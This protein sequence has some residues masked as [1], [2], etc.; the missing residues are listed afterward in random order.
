MSG[1]P[2]AMKRNRL[3]RSGVNALR[4]RTVTP[5]DALLVSYPKSGN[6]WLKFMLAHA[7]TGVAATF[8]A[9]EDAIGTVGGRTDVPA[10]LPGGGRI[11]KSLEAFSTGVRAPGPVVYVVRDGRDVAVSYYQQLVRKGLNPGAFSSYL[12][13]FVAGEVDG[14]GPWGAHV[15]SWLDRRVTRERRLL[16]IRYE[17]LLEDPLGGLQ[18][19]LEFLGATVDAEVVEAAVEANRFEQMRRRETDS[20]FH[21]KQGDKFFV[22]RGIAGEWRET[23]SEADTALFDRA[24]GAVLDRLGYMR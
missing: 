15:T 14:Y 18:Q 16:T 6:T 13:R 20:A 5:A 9:T 23:F 8:D 1:V 11:L 3:L 22:R 12:P 4:H 17:D 7:L 2:A 10:L 21:A 19:T 24:F